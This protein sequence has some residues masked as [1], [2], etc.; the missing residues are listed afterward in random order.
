MSDSSDKQK[1]D[2]A[3]RN[4]AKGRAAAGQGKPTEADNSR[5][6]KAVQDLI[7]VAKDE[8]ADRASSLVEDTTEKLQRELKSRRTQEKQTEAGSEDEPGTNGSRSTVHERGGHRRHRR[9]RRRLRRSEKRRLNRAGMLTRD[10]RNQKICGVCAGIAKY[11]GVDAWVVRFIAVTGL[12]FIPQV[13]FP[14]YIIACIVLSKE[15]RGARNLVGRKGRNVD[16]SVYEPESESEPEQERKRTATDA[17]ITPRYQLKNVQAVLDQA[18]L[19]LRRM[20]SHIT[21]GHYELQKEL[22]SIDT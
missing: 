3:K 17:E 11:R 22:N 7:S 4:K 5:L 19:R 15:P 16:E 18:E 21:S 13:T 6:E 12:I 9:S 20:E 8:F 1:N 14:A 10:T 2:R